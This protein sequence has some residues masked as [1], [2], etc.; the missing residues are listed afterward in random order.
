MNANPNK[1]GSPGVATK[2]FV[3]SDLGRPERGVQVVGGKKA[4]WM[5]ANFEIVFGFSG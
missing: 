2:Q 4:S 1:F 5:L 3:G